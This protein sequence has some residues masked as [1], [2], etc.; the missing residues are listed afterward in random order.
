[1][2][3]SA[4]ALANLATGIEWLTS[5]SGAV[6]I[7][8]ARSV[9]VYERGTNTEVTVYV[10][11]SMGST[12]PQPLLTG[13]LSSGVPGGV[14]GYVTSG[15]SIDIVDSESGQRAQAEALAVQDVVS[16]GVLGAGAFPL[17]STVVTA[18]SSAGHPTTGAWVTGQGVIDS[19]G[20]VWYCTAG[21]APGTWVEGSSGGGGAVSSVF[22]RTGTVVATSGDYSVAEV[23]GA[24]PLASPALTGAPTAPTAAALTDSTQIATTAYTDSAITAERTATATYSNKRLT[25]RV[26][27]VT[28]SATPTI[29]TDNADV[30]EITGLAEAITSMTTNLSGT[31]NDGDALIVRITD[32]GTARTITWGASFEAST[33]ALPTTTVTSTLL[34]VGFFWNAATSK[35]RCVA[36]A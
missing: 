32:N 11:A 1:M 20:V 28:Q 27:A 13:T 33:V 29:D 7:G 6:A 35:W 15:Q 25:R 4:I 24:A 3:A 36:V 9:F 10:S 8:Q 26:V 14:P 2:A 34:T 19:N 31:P 5:S 17:P 23:T 30:V 12:L 16:G 18:I 21:G 22:G